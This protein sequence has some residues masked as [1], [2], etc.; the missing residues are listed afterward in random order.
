METDILVIARDHFFIM[1]EHAIYVK[2]S[3]DIINNKEE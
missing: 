3:I 1:D 2:P